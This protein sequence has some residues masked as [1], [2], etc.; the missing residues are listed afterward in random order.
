MKDNF[1]T[2]AFL[3]SRF[4]PGYPQQLY[5]FLLQ[6]LS[7]K[8]AAWDCG[9]G[10][11][12]VAEKL[13]QYFEKVYATDISTN[14]LANAVRKENIFYS[15]ESAEQISF[16]NNQFDLITVAQ[17]IHWFDFE[18]F[19]HEAKRTLKPNGLIAVF[20][21]KR[22]I[23]KE[24]DDIIDNFYKSVLGVYWDKERSYVDESY[25]TIPFPFKEIE[26]TVFDNAYEWDIDQIIGYLSTWSAVQHF[27]KENN[28]NPIA[29]II[30]PLKRS[31]GNV[32]KR[33]VS[34]P[35]FMRV[36]KK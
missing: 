17:A 11:G 5:D 1:S 30:E 8:K 16:E 4:R 25:T 22:V 27:I 9:T 19:Y 34:F 15:L 3:Y 20:G 26:T 10:N 35:I 21:Y 2:Q 33:K 24:I 23:N 36:G 12:Q 31:W 13:S 14:Q 18:K 29:E 28:R 7:E 32:E 6:L